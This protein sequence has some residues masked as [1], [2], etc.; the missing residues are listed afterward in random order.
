MAIIGSAYS[1][2]EKT[3]NKKLAIGKWESTSGTPGWFFPGGIVEFKKD[4]KITHSIMAK[5]KD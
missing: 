4:G 1:A 5:G 2:D 3:D